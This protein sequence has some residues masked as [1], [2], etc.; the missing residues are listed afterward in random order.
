MGYKL[1]TEKSG[2]H[3]S[4]C[5]MQVVKMEEIVQVFFPG[6]PI[7]AGVVDSNECPFFIVDEL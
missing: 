5:F 4:L 3:R 1:A 7:W 2:A 6:Y